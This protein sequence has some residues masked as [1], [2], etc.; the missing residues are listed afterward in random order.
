VCRLLLDLEHFF[1]ITLSLVL[2]FLVFERLAAIGDRVEVVGKHCF[3][4]VFCG[5]RHEQ[6]THLVNMLG[7]VGI[8]VLDLKLNGELE[9]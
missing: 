8:C 7:Q 1:E 2:R 9:I 6:I 5:L 3:V 4:A